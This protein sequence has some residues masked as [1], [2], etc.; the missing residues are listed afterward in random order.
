[1]DAVVDLKHK[2][3][4]RNLKG[5]YLSLSMLIIFVILRSWIQMGLLSYIP[6]YYINYLKGDPLYAGR[7]IFILLLGSA[8]GTLGIAPLADRWGH[9]RYLIFSMLLTTAVAPLFL[10][11]EGIPL[12]VVL[13][14]L[15]M[16]IGSTYSVTVVM[17]QHLMPDNLGVA[18]GLIVGFA[19]GAGGICVTILGVIA[20]HYGVPFALKSIVALP[21]FGLLLSL[22]LR[23][24]DKPAVAG[25]VLG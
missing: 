21:F 19:V 1:V 23:Y 18:S 15:G 11:T 5:V 9:K 12:F 17:A 25:K 16:L 3:S 4:S 6:F 22:A 10:F 20:D 8:F 14:I 2:T 13:G 7:L 24:D